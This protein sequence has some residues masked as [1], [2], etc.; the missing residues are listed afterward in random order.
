MTSPW[1]PPPGKVE[2]AEQRL[3]ATE[4]IYQILLASLHVA[5]R[6]NPSAR[7]EAALASLLDVFF[8]L[9]ASSG[10]LWASDYDLPDSVR[11]LAAQLEQRRALMPP[12]PVVGELLRDALRDRRA[13]QAP[14][15][16]A[17]LD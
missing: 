1:T 12:P 13:P 10:W 14:P 9:S 16:D 7:T 11:L 8:D 3:A 6:D 2:E 15:G 17:A 5:A 4:E